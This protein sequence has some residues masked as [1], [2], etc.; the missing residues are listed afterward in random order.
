M[1][2]VL[3]SARSLFDWCHSF[4]AIGSIS[5]WLVHK[6][7]FIHPPGR[8]KC[9]RT[10]IS[11]RK[12]LWTRGPS[13]DIELNDSSSDKGCMR[14]MGL[15]GAPVSQTRRD[16]VASLLANGSRAFIWE[17]RRHRLIES[18][19]FT[20]HTPFM[21]PELSRRSYPELAISNNSRPRPHVFNPA[22]HVILADLVMYMCQYQP[23]IDCA[24]VYTIFIDAY[25]ILIIN[26]L[27]PDGK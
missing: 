14:F 19:S 23:I 3:A 26:N 15:P 6:A 22:G 11:R 16:A 25:I 10:S 17:L 9:Q 20:C 7:P 27:A 13:H 21:S 4:C 1:A 24:A 12:T 18:R 5:T 2:L 8:P